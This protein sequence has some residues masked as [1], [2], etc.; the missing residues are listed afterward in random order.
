M[1][2]ILTNWHWLTYADFFNTAT[3]LAFGTIATADLWRYIVVSVLALVVSILAA[4]GLIRN[5]EL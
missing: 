3:G 2:N 5:R 4:A 1:L